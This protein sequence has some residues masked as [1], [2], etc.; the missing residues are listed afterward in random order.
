ML[1]EAQK[2]YDRGDYPKAAEILAR[3]ADSDG[4]AR[5]LLLDSLGQTNDMAGIIRLF[6]PPTSATE[7]IYVMEALWK[8]KKH[9]RLQQ[10][11]DDP[12]IA[13]SSDPSVVEIR[14]KYALRLKK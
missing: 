8:E 12:I 5:R 2:F 10:I 3:V 7:A 9:D 1:L 4:L 13:T 14:T 11:L 6:D